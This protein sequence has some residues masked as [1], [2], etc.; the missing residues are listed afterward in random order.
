MLTQL[1]HDILKSRVYDVARETPLDVAPRLSRRL[2]SEVLLKSPQHAPQFSLLMWV[3]NSHGVQLA[4]LGLLAVFGLYTLG[5]F[6]RLLQPL[7][8]L[9][10]ASLNARNVFFE[11]GFEFLGDR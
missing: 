7:V 5:L 3:S 2:S 9:L 6:T 1:L 8:L 10:Y 4:F 11:D